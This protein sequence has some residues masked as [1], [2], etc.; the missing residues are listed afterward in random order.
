MHNASMK[1]ETGGSRNHGWPIS[2]SVLHVLPFKHFFKRH[3]KIAAL[4]GF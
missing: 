3:E 1:K 2:R 4:N